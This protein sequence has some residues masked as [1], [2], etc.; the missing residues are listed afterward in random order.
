MYKVQT[1]SGGVRH[2]STEELLIANHLTS[3]QD[4]HTRNCLRQNPTTST[5]NPIKC[6]VSARKKKRTILRKGMCWEG[7]QFHKPVA[8]G[9]SPV[10]VTRN[11]ATFCSASASWIS[12]SG[13]QINNQRWGDAAAS[14]ICITTD[15][16]LMSDC[17]IW[18]CILL[19]PFYILPSYIYS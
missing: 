9:N 18:L 12:P 14:W 6:I 19:V 15:A 7:P 4:C 1:I 2:R 3:L 8:S 13:Y 10:E 11:T 17:S 5:S 16:L